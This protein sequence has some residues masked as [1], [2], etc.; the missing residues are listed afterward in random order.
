MQ[1]STRTVLCWS[2]LFCSLR[3][4]FPIFY[5]YRCIIE[6]RGFCTS[7][8]LWYNA[9]KYDKTNAA[10]VGFMDEEY[11]NQVLRNIL[12]EEMETDLAMARAGKIPP[13]WY[14]DRMEDLKRAV[15]EELI[16]E[17]E[18]ANLLD[19][20]QEAVESNTQISD[21]EYAKQCV[22]SSG[23]RVLY[24]WQGEGNSVIEISK[25]EGIY[26]FIVYL[27]EAALGDRAILCAKQCITELQ[28]YAAA[29]GVKICENGVREVLQ[30]GMQ[31][32]LSLE[33]VLGRVIAEL[34]QIV[35]QY[36]GAKE[37]L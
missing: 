20:F 14:Q 24:I 13:S 1:A 30:R 37:N 2:V 27:N 3:Q 15:E 4:N 17:Q 29:Q 6:K 34:N 28:A 9:H 5:V 21:Q 33:E 31:T 35:A 11:Q 12:L 8:P 19:R 7:I 25:G 10:G 23:G 22:D 16:S 18:C 36:C 26:F 32:A